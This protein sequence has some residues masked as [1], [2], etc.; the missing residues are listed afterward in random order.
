MAEAGRSQD[1][2]AVL[3]EQILH[4]VFQPAGG[5]RPEDVR[6]EVQANVVEIGDQPLA[7]RPG[8]VGE[9]ASGRAEQRCAVAADLDVE[10]TP[11]GL[12]PR[13]R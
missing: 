6:K 3:A 10:P 5:D 1:V 2:P 11:F 7:G 9:E 12:R 8:Q 13:P 4:E